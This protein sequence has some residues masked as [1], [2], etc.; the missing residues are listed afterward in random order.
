MWVDYNPEYDR[1]RYINVYV[2]CRYMKVKYLDRG[3]DDVWSV[4]ICEDLACSA[5]V[6]LERNARWIRLSMSPS[7]IVIRCLNG[8][9]F[10]NPPPLPNLRWWPNKKMCTRAP[11]IRLHCRLKRTTHFVHRHVPLEGRK[12]FVPVGLCPRGQNYRRQILQH[13]KLEDIRENILECISICFNQARKVELVL[14]PNM[15][16]LRAWLTACFVLLVICDFVVS[17]I[18]IFQITFPFY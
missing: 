8:K 1:Y 18:L 3:W 11:K 7:W 6:I 12:R 15:Q 5:G 4:R 10:P 9:Y 16:A 14:F 2:W 17:T 13:L